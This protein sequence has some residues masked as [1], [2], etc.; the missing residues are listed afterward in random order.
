VSPSPDRLRTLAV[1]RAAAA[2]AL[3]GAGVAVARAEWR[4]LP[5]ALAKRGLRVEPASVRWIDPPGLGPRRALLLA[6]QGDGAN[7]VYVATARTGPGDLVIVLHDVSNLTRSRDASE[8]ALVAEGDYAAFVTRVGGDVVAFTVLDTRGDR[9]E[10]P[11]DR[12]ARVRIAVTRMQ[13]TGRVDGYGI[14]RFELVRPAR[15]VRLALEGTRLEVRAGERAVRVDLAAGRITEGAAF[16]RERPRLASQSGNWVTWAVDTVR[17]VPWIGPAPIA[18]AEAMAFRAENAVARARVAAIGDRTQ[19]E[20]AEDLADVLSA[21]PASATEGPVQDWPP[22]PLRGLVTPALSHEGEWSPVAQDDDPF[23][24]TNPGA[25]PPM[26]VTFVR[27]DTERPDSRVYVTVWDPRQIEIHVAPGSEEPIGATGETGTGAI[28]RDERTMSRLIAGFNGAFQAL[29]GEFGVYGEGTLLLPAKP[30]AATVALLADGTT[31]FGTWPQGQRDIPH[32]IVEF[33]QNLTPLIDGGAYNPWRRTFWGGLMGPSTDQHTARSG[34]CLTRE[35]FVAYFWGDALTPRSLGDGML[36]A[37]CDYGLHL[38]MNGANTGFEL[39]RV[40]TAAT[41]PPL[42]RPLVSGYEA[43]GTISGMPGLTFRARKLVRRMSEALPRY[44][45]RDPRDF[46]YLLLR[47]VLPGPPLVP[48]V[49]PAQPGEGNWHVAGLGDAPF[50]WPMARTR[51]RPDPTRPDRWVNLVRIDPRRVTLAPPDAS[52]G[53]VARWIGAPLAVAGELRVSMTQ[54]DAGSRWVIGTEGDGIA[55]E[56][57]RAGAAVLR[58][59]GIDAHGFLVFAVADRA[60]PDLVAR[61][62]DLAGCGPE[63]IAL[64]DAV[65]ALPS[66]VGAAGQVVPADGQPSLALVTREFPLARRMFPEVTP[67]PVSVWYPAQHRQVRYMVSPEHNGT[68]QVR[69]VGQDVLTLPIRG[70]DG[71]DA[72]APPPP[73]GAMRRDP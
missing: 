1:A 60:L 11:A 21:R 68:M 42:R 3:L 66:G 24:R 36:A 6:R 70:L 48:P 58:G 41:L 7:D 65:L 72:G 9:G 35:G 8:E 30:Y 49:S 25:P 63:R 13:Q 39:Y 5:E 64:A 15:I 51:V 19:R 69:I 2:C 34:I 14:D 26:Y 50:P 52:Q 61:A 59:A 71:R 32:E 28:P 55:G 29:H 10:A 12:G 53:V 45:R 40:G 56:P 37:R 16:V 23:V 73:S 18:W 31:A 27:T 20:V 38:D 43:E 62:L 54:G 46:F 57:L 22:A 47:P 67:V 44:I 17:A 33:R 4:P